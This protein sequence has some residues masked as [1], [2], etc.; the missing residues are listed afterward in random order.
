MQD[1][2]YALKQA[3]ERLKG[4]FIGR[5]SLQDLTVLPL[6]PFDVDTES[7]ALL[8]FPGFVNE[9]TQVGDV[10]CSQDIISVLNYRS[11]L[12][13]QPSFIVFDSKCSAWYLCIFLYFVVHSVFLREDVCGKMGVG[14]KVSKSPRN[15]GGDANP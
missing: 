9:F 11:N 13:V 4:L 14:H 3:R 12:Q 2:N 8:D 7:K 1:F 10:C 5:I 15:V 6:R